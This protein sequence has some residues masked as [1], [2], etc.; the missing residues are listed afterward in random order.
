[1]RF[2]RFSLLFLFI[3]SCQNPKSKTAYADSVTKIPGNIDFGKTDTSAY[4][5]EIRE[6]M[7]KLYKD[8]FGLFVHWGPY[9]QLEGIWDG[10][11]VSAEWIMRNA[12]IPIKDYER[13]K[14]NLF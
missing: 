4:T 12:P 1:M 11:E 3:F 14:Y 9:A 5:P 10:K 2:L 13:E 7:E 8:K 6:N